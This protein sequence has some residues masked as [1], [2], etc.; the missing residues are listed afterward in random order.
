MSNRHRYHVDLTD[1]GWEVMDE[2]GIA[3]NL[4][5][6]RRRSEAVR[7]LSSLKQD[8]AEARANDRYWSRL[9]SYHEERY[10]LGD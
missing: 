7:F 6:F 1:D 5:P 8:A 9:E 2:Y 3:V 4:E 10:E